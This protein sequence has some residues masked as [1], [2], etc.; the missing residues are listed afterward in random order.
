MRKFLL[1]QLSPLRLKLQ[2]L[3]EKMMSQK[4]TPALERKNTAVASAVATATAPPAAAPSAPPPPAAATQVK[5]PVNTANSRSRAKPTVPTPDD[6]IPAEVDEDL[7]LILSWP[8]GH[9]GE[10]EKQ[11]NQWL[12]R[13][14]NKL[15]YKPHLRAMDCITVE[16]PIKTIVQGDTAAEERSKVLFSCH[17][18]TVHNAGTVEM[19]RLVYDANFG[20][21]MLEEP[22]SI[23]VPDPKDPTKKVRRWTSKGSC[24]GADDGVGVWIMLKMI[25]AGVAGNYIFHRGEERGCLGSSAM[26]ADKDSRAWL[27]HCDIAVAFDRPKDYEVI[28]HQSSLK[29]ASAEHGNALAVALTNEELGLKYDTS[30]RGV[31]TDTKK[32]RGIIAECTNI[33]VGYYDHHS[34]NETLDYAH[35]SCSSTRTV[36]W[37]MSWSKVR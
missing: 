21:I 10:S 25:E 32:Y 34:S 26:L 14:L 15:G 7:T 35:A 27:E 1:R 4:A 12:I 30:D 36:M 11:F 18:D 24:L 22:K 23:E 28:T 33:G 5:Q 31:V 3:K 2:H 8:R 9:G 13:R 29:C 37:C 17:V 16:V 20:H 6:L 19:N